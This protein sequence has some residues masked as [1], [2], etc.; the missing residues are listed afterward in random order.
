[1]ALETAEI[2]FKELY[3]Q[4]L[5][6][7]KETQV[8]P[9]K[10]IW[11]AKEASYNLTNDDISIPSPADLIAANPSEPLV[12]AHPKTVTLVCKEA[13]CKSNPLSEAE[14]MKVRLNKY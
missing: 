14:L 3:S 6:T 8:P 1:M 2:D 9:D 12:Q 10:D 13:K 5:S 11:L 7:N 4:V